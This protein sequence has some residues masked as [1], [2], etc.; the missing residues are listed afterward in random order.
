VQV[1]ASRATVSAAMPTTT[2][3]AISAACTTCNAA[4]IRYAMADP[5]SNATHADAAIL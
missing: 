5:F 3:A 2:S 1:R 4:D